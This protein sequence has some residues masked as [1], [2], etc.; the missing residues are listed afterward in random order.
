MACRNYL[1]NI[2]EMHT[3]AMAKIKARKTE[4]AAEKNA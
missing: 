4:K 1:A 2:G 3:A